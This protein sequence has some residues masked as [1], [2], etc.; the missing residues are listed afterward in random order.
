[1]RSLLVGLLLISTTLTAMAA[2]T[3]DGSDARVGT[4]LLRQA[5]EVLGNA[6]SDPASIQF[7]ALSQPQDGMVCGLYNAKNK[8]GG[9]V[10]FAPFG[11]TAGD[12]QAVMLT[13]DF[14][15]S[16]DVSKVQ[17]QWK[18]AQYLEMAG[19]LPEGTADALSDHIQDLALAN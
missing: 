18:Y 9:Y 7:K 13:P 4:K 17:P 11:Y 2:E 19:C 3:I 12:P 6:L 16:K 15:S 1:M 10:G 8:F 14:M 5:T